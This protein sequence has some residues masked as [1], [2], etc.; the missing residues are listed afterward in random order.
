MAASRDVGQMKKNH[1]ILGL[2]GWGL[3]LPI[4]AIVPRY[5]KHKDPLWYYL[6]SV[7][8]VVGFIIGL[9]A[10]ILGRRLYD[11]IRAD[12]PT[13]RGIGIFVLVL[14]ILQVPPLTL[15]CNPV[16]FLEYPNQ[17]LA[18]ILIIRNLIE[19]YT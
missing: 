18:K 5:F 3:I 15:L 2:F 8:Q 12:F 16:V 17:Q 14:S 11:T 19:L 1:G 7:I 6:H 4:G 9:A 13:H 10:V